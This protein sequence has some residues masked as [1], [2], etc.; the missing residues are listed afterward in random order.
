MNNYFGKLINIVSLDFIYDF[1]TPYYPANG[2]P[3][4]GPASMFKML[5]VEYLY[6]IKSER[7]LSRKSN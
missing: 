6:S 4:V 1:V 7:D 5:L 2:C 3:S